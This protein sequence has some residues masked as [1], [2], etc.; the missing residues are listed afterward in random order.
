M[1]AIL[2]SW[3]LTEKTLIMTIFILSPLKGLKMSFLEIYEYT[4]Y[5]NLRCEMHGKENTRGEISRH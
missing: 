5:E 4:K 1:L 2:S 3:N